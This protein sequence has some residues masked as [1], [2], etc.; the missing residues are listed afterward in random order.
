MPLYIKNKLISYNIFK[1]SC[2][3]FIFIKSCVQ[4][5][6]ETVKNILLIKKN[7]IFDYMKIQYKIN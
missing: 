7:I 5:S 1:E 6:Y 4:T 2:V 3:R